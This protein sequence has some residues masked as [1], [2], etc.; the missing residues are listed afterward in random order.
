[1][2]RGK[3]RT[4][5]SNNISKWME[6]ER[7]SALKTGITI[8]ERDLI[9]NDGTRITYRKAKDP[10][11]TPDEVTFLAHTER[12]MDNLVKRLTKQEAVA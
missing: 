10:V 5:S 11:L 6:P 2:T 8:F 1:M 12:V 4:S 9:L 7:A 3:L